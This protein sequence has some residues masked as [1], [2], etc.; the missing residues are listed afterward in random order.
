MG[1][2]VT[3]PLVIVK[4]DV[5]VM[6]HVYSGGRL[7]ANAD[8]DHVEQLVDGGLVEEVDD[9]KAEEV[10]EVERPDGRGSRDK[11]ADY[12]K[13]RGASEDEVKPESE[14]GLSKSDLVAKYGN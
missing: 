13:T 14:G 3:A 5:G 7:P 1:Y 4:D 2:T 6:H 12:A 10:E 11:W 9:P 8:K